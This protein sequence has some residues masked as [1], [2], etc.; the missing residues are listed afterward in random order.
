MKDLL[1]LKN[2]FSEDGLLICFNGVF[3][4]GIIEEMGNAIKRYLEGENLDKGS[5]T[6]VFAV[7]IEQTQNVRN[8]LASRPFGAGGN[9]SAVIII[10]KDENGYSVSAGNVIAVSDVD[11]L[12]ERLERI[13]SQ[14]R[15]GLRA[16]Y[17]EQLRK[18]RDPSSSG[19]GLGLID[20]ARRATSRLQYDFK[21]LD[22]AHAFFSL[23]VAVAG[24]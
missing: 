2:E 10:R 22:G 1:Q 18:P 14:D 8:Y 4:H 9:D 7:Y 21:E 13:N 15:A 16:M 3:T 20:M 24:N 6:D 5:V 19:A 11:A 23:T 12:S 17:K